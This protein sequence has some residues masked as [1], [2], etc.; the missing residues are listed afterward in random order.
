[1]GGV[2]HPHTIHI[3]KGNKRNVNYIAYLEEYEELEHAEWLAAEERAIDDEAEYARYDA[4]MDDAWERE[5]EEEADRWLLWKES[6][7]R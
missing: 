6:Q 2:S 3:H 5:W 1:M 4:L 7:Y